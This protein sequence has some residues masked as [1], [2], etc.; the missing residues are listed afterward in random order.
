MSNRFRIILFCSITAVLIIFGLKSCTTVEKYHTF[1]IK[2]VTASGFNLS[3]IVMSNLSID[4][5]PPPDIG[6]KPHKIYLNFKKDMPFTM[7][8]TNIISVRENDKTSLDLSSDETLISEMKFK[9]P[10]G[11]DTANGEGDKYHSVRTQYRYVDLVPASQTLIISAKV[12]NQDGG[13]CEPLDFPLTLKS[14]VYTHTE[15]TS[16]WDLLMGIGAV[17]L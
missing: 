1:K 12:C 11:R 16:P 7:Q 6:A 10:D 2:D 4:S 17:N 9:V 3:G 14:G 13:A 8:I 15:F 5:P